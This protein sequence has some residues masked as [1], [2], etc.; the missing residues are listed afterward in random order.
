M[1]ESNGLNEVTSMLTYTYAHA[2]KEKRQL[3]VGLSSA[4]H[5]ELF[6]TPWT[7]CLYMKTLFPAT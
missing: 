7:T 6:F 4:H 3:V 2:L 5:S 1:L